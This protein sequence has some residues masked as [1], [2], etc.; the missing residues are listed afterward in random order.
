MKLGFH[1]P[2]QF[3]LILSFV[4]FCSSD[5]YA[6]GLRGPLLVSQ[7]PP[8]PT[9]RYEEKKILE[10]KEEES[11]SLQIEVIP[12]AVLSAQNS[13]EESEK[14]S[15]NQAFGT[16]RLAAVMVPDGAI[17][18]RDLIWRIFPS[19]VNVEKE[20]L[21]IVAMSKEA[22]PSFKLIA[23]EYLVQVSYGL[24]STTE[25]ITVIGGKLIEKK[26]ILDAGGMRI[27]SKLPD[28]KRISDDEV[29]YDIYLSRNMGEDRELIFRSAVP[30]KIVRLNAGN[31]HVVSRYGNVNSL[32][33]A[34]VAVQAGRLSEAEI[35]HAAGKVT[36]KLVYH[37]G[38]E[39]IANINWQIFDAD[40]VLVASSTGAF[41]RHI[42]A[43][44]E[45]EAVANC[46]GVLHRK[47]FTVQAQQDQE[48]E[49]ISKIPNLP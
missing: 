30:G 5:V 19:N 4:V 37:A 18:D 7:A 42:L 44:G 32:V 45:Y 46:D 25:K 33:E 41:S 40:R 2:L 24:A 21:D 43:E 27:I 34:D 15:L 23:T 10:R 31:Y 14:V 13:A 49:L 38:G 20:Q 8:V 17:L 12:S 9:L 22:S 26:M 16:L 35:Y 48:I 47:K 29:R 39:A 36:L 1:I 3:L 11:P 28:G 6:K